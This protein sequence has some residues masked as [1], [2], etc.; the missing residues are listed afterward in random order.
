MQRL[1]AEK[2]QLD[3]ALNNQFVAS[4]SYYAEV[5]KGN[6]NIEN[7]KRKNASDGRKLRKRA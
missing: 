2:K 7:N 6:L 5:N 1:L 4:Q 3:D